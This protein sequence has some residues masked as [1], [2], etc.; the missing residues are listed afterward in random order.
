[1]CFFTNQIYCHTNEHYFLF[2]LHDLLKKI[3]AVLCFANF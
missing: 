2:E 3:A 1:M